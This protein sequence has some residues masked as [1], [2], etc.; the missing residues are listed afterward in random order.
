MSNAFKTAFRGSLLDGKIP[1]AL[2][3]KDKVE[4]SLNIKNY[5]KFI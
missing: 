4:E 5:L 2:E 1:N 3:L